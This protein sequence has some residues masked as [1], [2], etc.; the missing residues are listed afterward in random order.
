VWL[1]PLAFMLLYLFTFD[2]W[3]YTAEDRKR[4]ER[5]LAEQGERPES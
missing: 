3:T 4:F 1:V 2:T 5:L